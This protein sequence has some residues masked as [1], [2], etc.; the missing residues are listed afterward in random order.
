MYKLIKTK[1]KHTRKYCPNGHELEDLVYHSFL[2]FDCPPELKPR[3]CVE[4]GA[5]ILTREEITGES[6]L[7]CDG[8]K[9]VVTDIWG[10]CP[11]CG[12]AK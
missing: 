1:E 3:F 5:E 4:C 7:E 10:F 6:H 11:Y 2:G 9:K 8:C 12:K